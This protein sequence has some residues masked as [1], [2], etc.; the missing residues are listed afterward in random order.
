MQKGLHSRGCK[1]VWMANYQEK[2][3]MNMHR[4]LDRYLGAP[5]ARD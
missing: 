3:I 5:T 4:E 2:T 1:Q